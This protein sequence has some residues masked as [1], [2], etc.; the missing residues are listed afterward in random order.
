MPLIAFLAVILI[1]IWAFIVFIINAID[2]INI[3]G[4]FLAIIM[5]VGVILGA[6]V[7]AYYSFAFAR[8]RGKLWFILW[9]I[10]VILIVVFMVLGISF[11]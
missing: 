9:V 11:S 7:A 10:A 8:T 3:D 4:P 6:L 5:N 2:A 1:G